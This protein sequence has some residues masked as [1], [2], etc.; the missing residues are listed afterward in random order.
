[1]HQRETLF[2]LG[3]CIGLSESSQSVEL[4]L[5]HTGLILLSS[6]TF[7]HILKTPD[8]VCCCGFT[9][10]YCSHCLFCVFSPIFDMQYLV[11]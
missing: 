1:M 2:R 9:V 10:C 3:G 5:S 11:S 6:F 7:Q 4:V 8:W